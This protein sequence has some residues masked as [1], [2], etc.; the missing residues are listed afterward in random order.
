MRGRVGKAQRGQAYCSKGGAAFSAAGRLGGRPKR[1]SRGEGRVFNRGGKNLGR[2][3]SR[4]GI[5][6][7]WEGRKTERR[8]KKKSASLQPR[9]NG[10]S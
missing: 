9:K 2:R 8:K 5:L 10:G 4:L 1:K 7:E 3:D 6:G